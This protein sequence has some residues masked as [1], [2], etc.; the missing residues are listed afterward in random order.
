MFLKDFIWGRYLDTGSVVHRLDP[1]TKLLVFI[2][3][4]V[5][6]FLLHHPI[7]LLLLGGIIFA[8]VLVAKISPKT[9]FQNLRPFVWLFAITL[10][11]HLFLTD[12]RILLIIPYLNWDITFEGFWKGLFFSLRIGLLILLSALLMFTTTPLELTD[13]MK[14]L[15]APLKKIKIPVDDLAMMVNLTLCFVPLVMDEAV[16]IRDAQLSRGLDFKGGLLK[17]TKN[18]IPLIVPVVYSTFRRADHLALAMEA[19]G[20]RGGGGRTSFHQLVLRGKDGGVLIG[21][22]ILLL[23]ITR[24]A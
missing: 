20:Y 9:A 24:Y 17:K 18:L 5:D 15:L 13:A 8:L 14:R 16:R 21:S 19:R 1:R 10:L 22:L 7:F 23:L 2:S 12:G 11:V 4:M 3:L 6:L